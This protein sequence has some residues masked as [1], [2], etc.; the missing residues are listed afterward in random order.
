MRDTRPL[1]LLSH[2]GAE[3]QTAA[4]DRFDRAASLFKRLAAA[5]DDGQCRPVLC[6]R[7][8]N[9]TT[10]AFRTPGDQ[11]DFAFEREIH[12]RHPSLLALADSL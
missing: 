6:E 4:A 11:G 3:C 7:E 1:L 8:R 5:R 10:D 2:I 9:R 12:C